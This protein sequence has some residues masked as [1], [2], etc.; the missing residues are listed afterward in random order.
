MIKTD[1]GSAKV[2]D[3]A[4]GET[5][6]PFIFTCEHSTNKLPPDMS[7]GLDEPLR[8]MHWASDIG[9]LDLAFYLG[10]YYQTYVVYPEY[11]RLLLDVNRVVVS[12]SMFREET[13]KD[14]PVHF[15]QSKW[16]V[17]EISAFW[18]RL[19]E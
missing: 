1:F 16:I 10:K 5:K 4:E 13:E 6:R 2:A 3:F 18:T 15:N 19:S 9:A 14:K 12:K 7:W 11:S 8:D 17:N